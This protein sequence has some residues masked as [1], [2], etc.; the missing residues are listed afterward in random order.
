MRLEG[1]DK[2]IFKITEKFVLKRVNKNKHKKHKY[3]VLLE[4][5]KWHTVALAI[6]MWVVVPI[7]YAVIASPVSL[8]A[9]H[10]MIWIPAVALYIVE[11]DMVKG[12]GL[13]YQFLFDNR[14]NPLIYK[15]EKE[16]CKHSFK[17]NSQSRV[18]RLRMYLFLATLLL[19]LSWLGAVLNVYGTVAML[20]AVTISSTLNLMSDYVRYVFD[21]D[22]P[23][24]KK[25]K[26][27]AKMTDLVAGQWKQMSQAAQTKPIGI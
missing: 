20:A 4:F 26:E 5:K 18:N 12:I 25:K 9:I 16:S 19:L 6:M 27:K 21:F 17:Q 13:A 7:L 14:K 10:I 24:P 8:I 1:L 11:V 23:K 22:P 2:R 3:D 15:L